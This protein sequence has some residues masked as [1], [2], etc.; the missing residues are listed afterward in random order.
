MDQLLLTISECCKITMVGRTKFYELV[1]SGQIPVRK[2][3]KKTL[4][5]AAD[6]KQWAERLPTTETA[7][8]LSHA[9]PA[10]R[11]SEAV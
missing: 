6:L 9:K 8:R 7:Q 3:G 2:V 10:T 4:V 1:G 5:A 11:F